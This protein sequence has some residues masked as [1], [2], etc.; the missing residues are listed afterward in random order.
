MGNKGRLFDYD[1]GK[2][3]PPLD[4]FF[5]AWGE[6]NTYY[7]DDGFRPPVFPMRREELRGNAQWAGKFLTFGSV[8]LP[9]VFVALHWNGAIRLNLVASVVIGLM[10]GSMGLFGWRLLRESRK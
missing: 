4:R 10:C 7:R 1:D 5:E 9:V 6:P 3:P 2:H 8:S